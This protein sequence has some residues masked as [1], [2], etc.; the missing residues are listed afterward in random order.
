[1]RNR[2]S[3]PPATHSSCILVDHESRTG[4]PSCK[5]PLS[6]L[7]GSKSTPVDLNDGLKNDNL[8]D[9]VRQSQRLCPSISPTLSER[10]A[11]LVGTGASGIDAFGHSPTGRK[12]T[13]DS[14]RNPL[15][16]A[17]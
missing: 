6:P 12:Q 2:P 8:G 7:R 5:P 17:L 3:A 1:M 16:G 15:Y 10:K 14:L 9:F 11:I 13:G 4:A